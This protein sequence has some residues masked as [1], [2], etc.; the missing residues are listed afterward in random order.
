M[1]ANQK[2]NIKANGNGSMISPWKVPN[3]YL[4]VSRCTNL[5][6]E[7][8]T[9]YPQFFVVE[10]FKIDILDFDRNGNPIASITST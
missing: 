6:G 7:L 9:I 8:I 10:R 1:G 2:F 3:M 4:N 5:E